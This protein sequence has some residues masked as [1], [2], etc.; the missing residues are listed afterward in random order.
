MIQGS[1][2]SDDQAMQRKLYKEV[3]I[4]V[5][6]KTGP[7]LPPFMFCILSVFFLFVSSLMCLSIFLFFHVQQYERLKELK[8]KLKLSV[9]LEVFFSFYVLPVFC[10]LMFLFCFIYF[11]SPLSCSCFDYFQ[12]LSPLSCLCFAFS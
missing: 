3:L 2:S 9:T 11:L 10:L 8:R 7:P 6:F 12:F 1:S 5:S 4:D